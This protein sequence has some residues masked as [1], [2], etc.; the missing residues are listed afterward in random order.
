VERLVDLERLLDVERVLDLER[1]VDLERRL[2]VELARRCDRARARWTEL[3]ER[4]GAVPALIAL[5]C[6]AASAVAAGTIGEW[7]QAAS[8][9]QRLLVFAVSALVLQG[10]AVEVYGRGS[11]SFAN[12]G[13]LALGFAAGVGP[14][15]AVAV[16]A[17]VVRLVTSRGRLYR[18]LYDAAQLSL[19]GAAGTGMYLLLVGPASPIVARVA[20]AACAAFL[21]FVVNATLLCAAMSLEGRIDPVEVWRE[22][23][24]WTI[25]YAI[26]SGPLA[27]AVVEAYDRLGPLGLLAFVMPPAAMMVA[28]RQY[29][30]RTEEH[31][32][33]LREKNDELLQLA[34]EVKRTHRD[35]IAALS[36]SMEAK[37]MYTGGHVERVAD[38]AVGL[39][40]VLGYEGA[41]L[42]AIEIGALLHDIGKIGIPES[43]LHKPG[44]LDDAEW[45]IMRRHP[46]VSE[47]ILSEIADLHPAVRQIARWSHERIDGRGY[48][49]GLRGDDI[50]LPARIVLVADAYDALTSDRPYRRARSGFEAIAEIKAHAGT[51]FCPQVVD[52]LERLAA[53][54][55]ELASIARFHPVAA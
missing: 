28:V 53:A 6:S 22:R 37:D 35:T 49:D 32:E 17:A 51:Q 7:S 41:D 33:E 44:P 9:P 52:A 31:V 10:L 21:Y 4:P 40:R 30:T 11:L 16:A 38:V 19:A 47:L 12:T 3:G 36:R 54:S 29:V 15:V 13:I 2:D 1:L 27:V 39:G 55:P 46:V 24:G 20:A 14:A 34:A 18:A 5:V 26:V 48:P 50:P 45:G 8:H 23:F 42:D 43:I 25:W